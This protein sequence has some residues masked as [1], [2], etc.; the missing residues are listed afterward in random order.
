MLIRVIAIVL[1]LNISLIQDLWLPAFLMLAGFI[2]AMFYSF[3]KSKEATLK[4]HVKV[5]EK[6]KSPFSIAPALKF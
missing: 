1:V 2:I 4:T 5:E 3:H 6:I